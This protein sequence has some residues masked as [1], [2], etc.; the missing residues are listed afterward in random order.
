MEMPYR[1]HQIYVTPKA[2]MEDVTDSKPRMHLFLAKRPRK[3]LSSLYIHQLRQKHITGLE[4]KAIT[5]SVMWKE[6]P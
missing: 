5:N 2:V 3:Y 4:D 1:A 6:L